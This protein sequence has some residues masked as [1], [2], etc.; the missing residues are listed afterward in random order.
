MSYAKQ[1]QHILDTTITLSLC[2][3]AHRNTSFDPERRAKQEQSHFKGRVEDAIKEIS[4][5]VNDSNRETYS[6]LFEEFLTG[7]E[8]RFIANL[9]SKANCFSVMITGGGN[10]NNRRHQ[11]ANDA[12]RK[13]SEDLYSFYDWKIAKIK[14]ALAP[15]VTLK[16]IKE[17]LEIAEESHKISLLL[18]KLTRNKKLTREE[19]L[20]Q[21]LTITKN[22]SVLKGFVWNLDNNSKFFTTNS[23]SKIKRLKSKLTEEEAFSNTENKMQE[24]DGFQVV[25]NFEIKRYQIL[26]DAIP[27]EETRTKLKSLGFRWSPKATAW[28]VHLTNNGRYKL[29]LFVSFFK[30]LHTADVV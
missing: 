28:Q 10:F 22:K 1:I 16:T 30:E 29:G 25:F 21:A 27:D 13:K 14:K 2:E 15:V 4:P 18:N 20:N 12:E 9:R 17:Q 5:L 24:F 7:Y 6:K 11:K 3:S 8:K 19:K 26:F 23:N